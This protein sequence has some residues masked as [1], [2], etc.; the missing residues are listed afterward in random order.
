MKKLD[1]LQE[2]LNW[3]KKDLSESKQLIPMRELITKAEEEAKV[4]GKDRPFRKA[5]S[6]NGDD[7]V[8]I[9][10][11]IK[12][13]SPSKG[14]IRNDFNVSMWAKTYESAGASAIS[15]LTEKRFFQGRLDD[16]AKVKKAVKIPVFRKDFI[17][18]V[19]QIYETAVWKADAVLLIARILSESEL[20]DFI[21]LADELSLDVLVE[22]HDESDME[23]ALR[24]GAV[25]IGI[26]NRDLTTFS[27]SLETTI[28]LAEFLDPR[29]HL[30]V[31]ESG[32]HT[33]EDI[34][35]ITANTC[36]RCFLVGEAI[37]K[38]DDP[39]SMIR[40]LKN[41]KLPTENQND[42]ICAD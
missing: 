27:V 3:R 23:K 26:N 15:V 1:R 33:R 4:R 40:L 19:Y 22:T 30:G 5:I 13:A 29:F 14:L 35:K 6:S 34:E 24:A 18:D 25:I 9:I 21:A 12:R 42:E 17:I 7:S 37:M 31:S 10:A 36:I 16:L 11:E 28:R 32:I 41:E 8:H 2:I 20:A 39:A 38:S